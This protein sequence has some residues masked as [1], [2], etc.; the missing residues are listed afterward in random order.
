[1]FFGCPAR[2]G[3]R[4]IRHELERIGRARVF[5]LGIVVEIADARFRIEHHVFEHRAEALGGGIDFR[6]GLL[7]QLDAFGVAA[8][9]EV[10]H[11]V[12]A[13]AVLVVADQ[14][15]VRIGRERGLAG[16][17][18]PEE[19]RHVA[20]VADI[21][22]AV[23]R[24]H[25]LRRQVEV[26]RGE[27]RLL[28][29]ARIG[30]VADQD[31][32]ARE[33][34]RDDGVGAHAMALGIG[35]ERRQVD[36]GEFGDEIFEFDGI[37]TDQK[38]ADKQRVPG[39]FGEDPGLDAVFRIGAAI[40]VLRVQLLALRV[41]NEIV[42]QEL[43][44]FGRELA[45]ALPPHRFLGE[46]VADRVLVLGGSAGMDAGLRADRSALDQRGFLGGQRMFIER[47]S[48]E[49]PVHRGQRV[50]TEFVGAVS[51]VPQTRFLH[52]RPPTTRPAAAGTPPSCRVLRHG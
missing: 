18:E 3:A 1:M 51:A 8:A 14:R 38:L 6:L 26:E 12:R 10:E 35:L 33:V 15:A 24:H 47:R 39:Q 32:L 37:R 52:G 36:D 50:E 30:R 31:D 49:I 40:E 45:V 7:R 23:H 25:A 19:Q 29:L 5:R 42:V 20:V 2:P 22:R 28:D 41:R 43:K 46:R 13:P 27:D 21:G 17:G 48:V 34:D 44:L 16:A 9:L 4:S 11:A